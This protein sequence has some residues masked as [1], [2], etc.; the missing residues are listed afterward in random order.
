MDSVDPSKD[1]LLSKIWALS[2]TFTEESM[3]AAAAKA[4]E[5]GFDLNRGLIPLSESFINLSSARAVLEDAIEKHKLVQLPLTVQR[6]IYS[7]LESIS[8]ALQ[9][10]TNG[11]DE[12]VTL[13]TAVEALNT[14]I[15]KY[16]LHNLS[17]QVLGYQKKLNQL[18]NQEVHASQ[19]LRILEGAEPQAQAASIAA[20]EAATRKSEIDEVLEQARKTSTE[21]LAFLQQAKDS[22]VQAT[23]LLATIQQ[24]EKQSG[25]LAASTK[26]ASNDTAA[27]ATTIKKFYEE[28]DENRRKMLQSQEE[29]GRLITESDA[30]VKKLIQETTTSTTSTISSLR[31]TVSAS[32]KQLSAKM[33]ALI[34]G[35]AE[36]IENVRK[37]H[38]TAVKSLTEDATKKLGDLRIDADKKIDTKLTELTASV[39]TLSNKA[40]ED[41]DGLQKGLATSAKATIEQN[42]EKTADLISE[43]AVLKD[44]IRDQIQQATG[45]TLFG[46]FQSRQNEIA[47]AKNRWA[48]AIAGLIA[49]S[50]AVTTWIAYEAGSYHVHDFAFWVKLSLTIPIGFALTFATV[51]YNRE[52]RLEEEYAFKSSI[53]VSLNPYRDLVHSILEKDGIVDKSKYTDFVI[54]S[55]TNVFTSPT[56]RV[57]EG[58]HVGDLPKKAFKDAAEIIGTAAKAMK[59]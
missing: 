42:Q 23:A 43:L 22:G 44:Q 26:T 48:Y 37:N 54:E 51:Q 17:D 5:L 13:T 11:S 52:R 35:T 58:E 6:E 1:D 59:G 50:A 19:L 24:N 31:E 47:S 4:T 14:S 57:F 40:K 8:K 49:I 41:L 34:V 18:K 10:L 45:F 20:K 32:E 16:G 3:K 25:E 33:D 27:V 46:A 36:S 15:W 9:G 12:I 28:I 38:E 2:T 30:A 55:V 53:S 29:A 7:N 56:E 21:A 39:T